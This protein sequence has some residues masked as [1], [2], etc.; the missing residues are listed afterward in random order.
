MTSIFCLIVPV[1]SLGDWQKTPCL[2]D[3]DKKIHWIAWVTGP[4]FVVVSKREGVA[5]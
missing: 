1:K 3:V 5:G 4:G 2:Y